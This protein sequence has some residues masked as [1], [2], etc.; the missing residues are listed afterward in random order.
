M[1]LYKLLALVYDKDEMNQEC[2]HHDDLDDIF[3]SPKFVKKFWKEPEKDFL[4]VFELK[5]STN[6]Y[7]KLYKLLSLSKVF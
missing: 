2:F 1:N 6:K 5:N 3:S 7:P 4:T